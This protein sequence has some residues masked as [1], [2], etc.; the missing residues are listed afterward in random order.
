M[1]KFYIKQAWAMVKQNK[2]FTSIYV[3]GTALAI[4]TTM[5]MAI[6]YYVK[7][8]PIYPEVNRNHTL[9]ISSARFVNPTTQS[10]N[11]WA[12]SLLAV[13]EWF[14][15]LQ[16]VEAVSAEL[17]S[18]NPAD[19]IQS[20]DES[21]DFLVTKKMID[22]AFFRIYSFR[23]IEGKPF[24]ESDLQSGIRVAVITES[25]ARR[26]FSTTHSIVGKVFK[27]NFMEY[28]VAGVVK[29]ASFLTKKS[30]AQVYVPY[31][32][33]NE[34]S[35]AN[36]LPYYGAYEITLLVNSE[37]QEAALRKEVAEIVR[38]YNTS[39]NE[40]EL[41]IFNQPRS[42]IQ[43]VFQPYINEEFSWGEVI[44]HYFIILLVLLLVPALNLSGMIAGRMEMR[45]PEMGIRKSFGAHRRGLLSQVMWEN[46]ILTLTGGLLG[47][48]LA[49]I[50]LVAFRDW[51]FALFDGIPSLPVEGVTPEVSGEMLFAPSVFF[52][53]L[54]LC[55][56]LN[57]LSA[58][59]PAW[60]SLHNP[61]IRSLNEK[62]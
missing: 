40:W 12:F 4:A 51:L 2:L 26:I 48:I 16:N 25:L 33:E 17:S 43:S 59:I 35:K 42:H 31:T 30:F 58:L 53:A 21:G 13:K 19:Y 23:F 37:E 10:S 60:H 46:L 32:S 38:K 20:F 8:A 62:R 55:V 5:I 36:R 22:P 6:V 45:L 39:Q 49:W 11:Q 15:P 27:M 29:E 28:R 7:I 9:Y 34:S 14:Y 61:I 18:W 54:L 47:L 56:L 50:G 41:Q 1:I 57:L 24:T 44:R 3:A 52:A